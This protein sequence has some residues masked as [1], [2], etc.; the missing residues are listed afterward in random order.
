MKIIA[1]KIKYVSVSPLNCIVFRYNWFIRS[2]E[3][4]INVHLASCMECYE[5]FATNFNK[6][7]DIG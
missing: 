6:I 4:I 2:L 1:T 5:A 7:L 3:T